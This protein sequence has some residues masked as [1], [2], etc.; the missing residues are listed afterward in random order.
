[1]SLVLQIVNIYD[2]K[3]FFAR[4]TYKNISFL[5]RQIITDICN[6]KLHQIICVYICI[7]I[8]HK[9]KC[10]KLYQIVQVTELLNEFSIYT[11]SFLGSKA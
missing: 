11:L 2:L 5:S 1:M 8:L 9:S 7:F 10:V 6:A 3:A 4:D